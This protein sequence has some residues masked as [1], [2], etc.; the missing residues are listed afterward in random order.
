MRNVATTLMVSLAVPV[1]ITI[2]LGV[3]YFLGVSLNI[4]SMMGLMLAVGMLVD[5]A[6]V[7][8]ESIQTERDRAKKGGN[9]VILKGVRSVSLAVAAGTLTSAAVF[10]P[11]I[12]GEPDQISIF[13]TH[14]AA[15]IVVSLAVS[16]AIS[17][18]VIPMI[19]SRIKPPSKVRT[20]RFV[21]NLR[22][23]YVS[24]L[25]WTF[26][27]R[28]WSALGIVIAL[29]SAAIPFSIVETD[30][31]PQAE[32]RRLFMPMHLDANYPLAKVKESVDR[33][34]DYLYANQERFEIRN[35]YTYYNEEGTGQILIYLTD[36][37]E[38]IRSAQVISD[39]ILKGMP[40]IAIGS[41]SF[42]WDRSGGAESLS[43]TLTG[44]SSEVL[45]DLGQE[46]ERVLTTI[47]GIAGASS[48][49]RAGEQELHVRVN[50]ERAAQFGFSS[51][52]VG[53]AVAIAM[54]G[55][56][57]RE[58][59]G[60][61]GEIPIRLQFRES[62][63]TSIDDLRDLKL[64]NSAGVS[65]P[66]MALVD[67][68]QVS[69]PTTIRRLD[70]ET[71]LRITATLNEDFTTDKARDAIQAKL[72]V[73]ALPAGYDWKFGGGFNDDQEA[74]QKMMF[75]IIL[76]VAIIYIVLAAQFESLLYPATMITTIV[77]S[78]IGVFWFFLLTGTDFT[79][80]A[81]IGILILIGVVVNNGIVM[82][83]HINQLRLS[84]MD[85]DHALIEAG[86]E[87]LRPILMT[88]GTTVLGLLPLCIGNTQIGGDG[89]PYFPMARAIVGGL[90]FSTFV[91]L[92]FLPTI[93]MWLDVVR[94]WPGKFFHWSGAKLSTA[95]HWMARP[96]R[97]FRKA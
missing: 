76:G 77:F 93:Y 61:E 3:M 32:S 5:N 39:E 62:D 58:F 86:R 51:R 4:L 30:M 12:F 82:I 91:S 18:T 20:S 59:K 73:M 72:D 31:F 13:L 85:R 87:R 94:H 42:T 81:M 47:D 88:V 57:L 34:E 49:N 26:A 8:T 27:H 55:V 90:L 9:E 14:V 78:I 37:D 70:R 80:M 54:R 1:S 56:N 97:R 19:A 63:R 79:L 33:I 89:P 50:R 64:R 15:A 29:G 25:R 2:T 44:R 40:K 46:V 16:L 48:A 69:G 45:R 17:Q 74:M 96:V 75:N 68:Q 35:V 28:W 95:I 6:V 60:A 36:D 65:I 23:R 21:E 71:G 24:L 83:D 11:I 67:V 43:V 84:G 38:A 52:E 22:A 53:E 92:L 10:L 66:I 41:P 7:I